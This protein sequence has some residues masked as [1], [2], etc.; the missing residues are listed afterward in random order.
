[1]LPIKPKPQGII[2][3]RGWPKEVLLEPPNPCKPQ[4]LN[5]VVRFLL[6]TWDDDM[7]A[8]NLAPT[9]I[10]RAMLGGFGNLAMPR[11]QK[12]VQP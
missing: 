10:I 6:G 9:S 8:G 12:T 3:K 7:D 1:M 5:L 11:K 4:A 2:Y